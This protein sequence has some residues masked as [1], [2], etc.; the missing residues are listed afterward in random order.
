MDV[1]DLQKYLVT[2]PMLAK[3]KM[4]LED[5]QSN[6]YTLRLPLEPNKNHFNAMSAGSLFSL[7]DAIGGILFMAAFDS[8]K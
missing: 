8:K 2:L 4:V 1:V 3:F 6:S 7:G 5:C